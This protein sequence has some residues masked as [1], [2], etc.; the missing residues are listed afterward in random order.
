MARK[1]D[2]KSTLAEKWMEIDDELSDYME[3][4]LTHSKRLTFLAHKFYD[5][6]FISLSPQERFTTL[7]DYTEELFE[8]MRLNGEDCIN[9]GMLLKKSANFELKLLDLLPDKTLNKTL[10]EE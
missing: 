1:E 4:A 6:D 2:M 8:I 7:L 3:K 5:F 9:M 10:E